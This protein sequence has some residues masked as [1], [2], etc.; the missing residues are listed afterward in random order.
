VPK[1]VSLKVRE[2]EVQSLQAL[3]QQKL[4]ED[5]FRLLEV[6]EKASEDE[7]SSQIRPQV[8][9]TTSIPYADPKKSY[10][11]EVAPKLN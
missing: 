8:K 1:P 6:R 3:S 4:V 5:F 7:K 10:M 11:T 9:P 2:P